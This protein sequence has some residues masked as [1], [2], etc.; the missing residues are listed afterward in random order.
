[1]IPPMSFAKERLDVHCAPHSRWISMITKSTSIMIAPAY[2]IT[3]ATA[4]KVA[5]SST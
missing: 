2:T 4:I 3:W 5:L 1:M